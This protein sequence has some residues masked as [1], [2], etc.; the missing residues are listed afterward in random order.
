MML[1][2][3]CLDSVGMVENVDINSIIRNKFRQFFTILFSPRI[4]Q[5]CLEH[6]YNRGSVFYALKIG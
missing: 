5:L 4:M 2:G 6:L 1:S 3:S